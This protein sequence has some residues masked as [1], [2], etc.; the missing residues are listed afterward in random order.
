MWKQLRVAEHQAQASCPASVLSFAEGAVVSNLQPEGLYC[1]DI[2]NPHRNNI[3][4]IQSRM[5]FT[6]SSFYDVAIAQAVPTDEKSPLN[7]A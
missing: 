5:A 7:V 3:C 4:V 2:S 6:V 1:A